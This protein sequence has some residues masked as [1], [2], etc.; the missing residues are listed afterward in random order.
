MTWNVHRGT[1]TIVAVISAFAGPMAAQAAPA[2][3]GQY[4]NI[5]LSTLMDAGWSNASSLTS[6]LQGDHDPKVRGFTMPNT[7]MTLDGAVD[8]YFKGFANLVW[9]LDANGET[10][11]EMEEAYVM[12]TSLPWNLQVKAGQFFV[13]FGRQN[14]QHPHSWSFVDQPVIMSRLL[15]P[16]GLRSQGVRVS[17]LAPTPFYAEAMVSFVNSTNG[18]T[19][20]F[21]SDES[22]E[23]HGGAAA[24][25]TVENSKDMLVVPRLTTS[26][27]ITS[28]QTV[29]LGAS[30]A[31]GPNSGGAATRT[32]M[33]GADFYWKWK[34]ATAAQGFPFVSLQAEAMS[35]T[36]GVDS[37]AA[38]ADSFVTFPADEFVDRG[39]YAQL[40][41]GIKPR[42]VAGVRT[43]IANGDATPF[44]SDFRGDRLRVSPSFTWYPTEFSK[45]R[46]QYNY[47]DRKSVAQNQ[48]L[49]VQFEFL[50]GAHAAHKF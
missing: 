43:D 4:M 24:E 20:S 28:T 45:I 31:F 6:I 40:L 12:S 48:S 35:R 33:Y 38:V 26:F 21:R 34:S 42:V 49:W 23:I 19:F 46:F 39:G 15:G 16:E 32:S 1:A 47:D 36:Y 17:W 7:E 10:G 25:R 2:R 5:G 30:G 18:T 3:P 27:D 8:P 11:V 13:D 37:R 29:V 50:L 14:T 44:T 22:S 41:W 9:K